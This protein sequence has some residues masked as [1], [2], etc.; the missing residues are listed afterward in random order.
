MSKIQLTIKLIKEESVLDVIF[1][2]KLSFKQN[3]DLLKDIK[4]IETVN[5]YFYD[6]FRHLF[7]KDDI[8]IKHFN[9]KSN[10]YLEV[11]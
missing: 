2:E 6:P 11:Y 3:L 5:K 8:P 10:M 1:D 4:E 9:L 7:L